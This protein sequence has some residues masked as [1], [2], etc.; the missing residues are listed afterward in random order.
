[1]EFKANNYKPNEIL[2]FTRQK[3]KA[4]GKRN[5]QIKK[6]DKK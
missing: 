5:W 1:M 2:R 4:N 6:L 3:P